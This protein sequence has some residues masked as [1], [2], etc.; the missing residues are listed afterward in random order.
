MSAAYARELLNIG[1]LHVKAGEVELARQ[2]FD[3]AT[4]AT[5]DDK[6]LA[7]AWYCFS[8]V[9]DDPVTKRKMLENS[10][11]HDLHH[12]RARRDLAILDGKLK[13]DEIVDPDHLPKA[14]TTE[15]VKI[16]AERFV[17]PQCGARMAF[18]PDG[19]LLACDHCG[20][21]QPLDF[22]EQGSPEEQDFIIAMATE[23]GH[24]KPIL[25]HTFECKG[26]SAEFLLTP[27]VISVTCS[28][29]GTQHVVDLNQ[30]HELI[31]PDGIIPLAFS[32]RKAAYYLVEWIN[33]N[34]IQP[35]GKVQA[36][37]GLYLPAWTFDIGG[38]IDF[39]GEI[40]DNKEI[41]V[42]QGSRPVFYNDIVVP[43]SKRLGKWLARSIPD[44]H[45]E[46]VARYDSRCLADWPAEVY[47]VSMDDA[48]LE[49]RDQ[50]YRREKAAL[51]AKVG[52]NVYNLLT[53]SA[54]ISI[55]SFKLVLIPIWV[56]VYLVDNKDYTVIIN[57]QTG[58]VY[59]ELPVPGAPPSGLKE[60]LGGLFGSR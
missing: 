8:E 10:L 26:C 6:V 20:H 27:E 13:A 12:I 25:M 54:N 59:G 41:K 31:E 5:D 51:P 16:A 3:R 2:F 52:P 19:Q 43:A 30:L 28:Y 55:D 1:I 60:L 44:F 23:K 11:A 40:V 42:V 45:F 38:E 21:R 32:Q 17:C 15:P 48:S 24:R 33:Q 7:D 46:Q 18:T 14:R 29:C 34:K 35:Q 56:T 36:P 57:G 50:A 58:K 53:S 9:T 37:R 47:Q 4:N 49:A 22:T 39:T